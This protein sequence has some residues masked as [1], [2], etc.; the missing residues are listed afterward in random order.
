M[1]HRTCTWICGRRAF[2]YNL[3]N[4]T[5]RI[6]VRATHVGSKYV[7]IP[8]SYEYTPQDTNPPPF[9]GTPKLKKEGKT[10]VCVRMHCDLVHIITQPHNFQN[11][12]ICPGVTYFESMPASL[13]Y[14]SDKDQG[15]LRLGFVS[16]SIRRRPLTLGRYSLDPILCAIHGVF[17]QLNY[18]KE[19][20]G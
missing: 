5:Y 17:K 19:S 14:K 20:Y 18:N 3:S 2:E 8:P 4:F 13:T 12:C 1:D 15:S 9:W 11:S 16:L 7:Q 6:H 10:Y